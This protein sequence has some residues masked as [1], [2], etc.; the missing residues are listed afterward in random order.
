[1]K[2]NKVQCVL[3]VKVGRQ[4]YDVNFFFKGFD[5]CAEVKEGVKVGRPNFDVIF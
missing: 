3:G 2:I 4:N 5:F 1:M